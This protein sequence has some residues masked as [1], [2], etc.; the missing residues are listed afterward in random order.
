MYGV[1]CYPVFTHTTNNKGNGRHREHAAS[2]VVEIVVNF[3][4]EKFAITFFALVRRLSDFTSAS[5]VTR[6]ILQFVCVRR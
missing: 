2:D 4:L 3:K 6:L 5:Y 1:P